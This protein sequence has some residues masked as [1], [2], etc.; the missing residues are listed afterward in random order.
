MPDEERIFQLLAKI[1]ASQTEIQR[2]INSISTQM[3]L[4]EYTIE[5]LKNGYETMRADVTRIQLDVEKVRDTQYNL[6]EHIDILRGAYSPLEND[7]Q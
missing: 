5:P 2:D 7:V 4:L 3:T 6:V 1:A